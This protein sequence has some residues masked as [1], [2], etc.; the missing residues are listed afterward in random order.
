MPRRPVLPIKARLPVGVP[1]ILRRPY[2]FGLLLAGT[3]LA[4]GAK[5]QGAID[6]LT[7]PADTVASDEPVEFAADTMTYD[8]QA[9]LVTAEGNVVVTRGGYRLS[10][11][12]VVYDRNSGLVTATGDIT[13]IDPGGNEIYATEVQLTDELRDGAIDGFLLVLQDGG[14]LA[15]SDG[16]RVDGVSQLNRA[17]YSPC[18]VVDGTGCPK[19]PLWQIKAE[20]VQHDPEAGKVRYKDARFEFFGVPLLWLPQ[21]SHSDSTDARASGLLIPD[22]AIDRSTG[23]SVTQPYFLNLGESSDLT[24]SPTIYTEVNPSLGA[25]YRKLFSSGPLKVGGIATVSDVER[26]RTGERTELVRSDEARFYIYG[27]GQFQHDEHW[28]STFGIRAASDDTFLRRYDISRDTTLRNFYRLER[29]GMES[30]LNVE[31]WVF[32]GLRETDDQGLIPI[33]LPIVDFTY[34]PEERLV[35]GRLTLDASSAAI[36]RTDGMDSY[37]LSAG[38]EWS[39]GFITPMGQ[40]ITA[41]ALARA[42]AYRVEDS[43]LVEFPIYAGSDGWE[44]RLIPAA[45]LDVQWPF[46]GPAFGGTQIIT[47]R[48]QLSA[49]PTGLNDDIPNEDSRSVDLDT[50]NLFDISR[51][52]GHDRWEGGARVTYGAN[53]KLNRPRFLLESEIGQSYRLDDQPSILPKGTGLDDNFSDFVGRNTLRIGRRFDLTHR[54]RLDKESFR[55]RRNEIDLTIGGRRDYLTVGYLKLDRDIGIEDLADREEVRAGGRLQLARYW[56][57]FGSVIVDLT[58]AEEDPTSGADGFEPIRHRIGLTYEDECFR[59]GFTWKR[60]YVSDRDFERGNS[61]L[62]SVSLKTLGG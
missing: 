24:L 49:S 26:S 47:P 33:A 37:R 9:K 40:Q 57:A 38:A 4:S 22:L 25:E 14:R 7:A 1:A 45:A 23:V 39:R 59:F 18:D 13:V 19:Q 48:V 12:Q 42:D 58:D 54:Y 2:L 3:A 20:S 16:T 53:W 17:V 56:S 27:N 51:F 36:N 8:D 52:P 35:G 62:I 31:G 50:T 6:E 30:F 61:F 55:L 43:D 34:T 32:Q 44:G 41:T 15:A 29:S 60:D 5:A 21:L 28:R 10:A 11:N 46:A